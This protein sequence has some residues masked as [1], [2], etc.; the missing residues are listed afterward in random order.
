MR[1]AGRE[2]A[3]NRVDQEIII[4]G[5]CEAIEGATNGR[6]KITAVVLIGHFKIVLETQSP[7]ERQA[8]L[9]MPF[10]SKLM[11]AE[12]CAEDLQKVFQWTQWRKVAFPVRTKSDIV[13]LPAPSPETPEADDEPER[14]EEEEEH[15][16]PDPTNI[17]FCYKNPRFAVLV[18]EAEK[19]SSNEKIEKCKKALL[20]LLFNDTATKQIRHEP[21]EKIMQMVNVIFDMETSMTS[22]AYDLCEAPQ[23]VVDYFE[24]WVAGAKIVAMSLDPVIAAYAS[25]KHHIT[26]EDY[27]KFCD[28]EAYWPDENGRECPFYFR[29]WV[30]A[31]KGNKTIVSGLATYLKFQRTSSLLGPEMRN[32][33]GAIRKENFDIALLEGILD[34]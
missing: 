14:W 15:M 23:W 29:D 9:T 28:M 12:K 33:T 3:A 21:L 24:D 22:E 8:K 26:H 32:A 20:N 25:A 5:S 1:K 10:E 17:D 31:M 13:M 4:G 30:A 34:N 19:S 16:V 18:L 7:Y 2:R 11:L 27:M 6:L